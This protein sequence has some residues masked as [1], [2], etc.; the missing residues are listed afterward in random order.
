M[1]RQGASLEQILGHFYPG[2]ALS[3]SSGG[4]LRVVVHQVNAIPSEVFLAFPNGGEVRQSGGS[5]TEGFPVRVAPGEQVRIVWNGGRYRVDGGTPTRPASQAESAE[6]PVTG[7]QTQVTTPSSTTT[8]STTTPSSTTT[9]TAAIF[10]RPTTTTTTTPGDA[11][12]TT[13]TTAPAGT[14]GNSPES[15]VPLLASPAGGG[16][17]TI[18]VRGRTY[19]GVLE[20]S[21]SGGP[22]RVVNVVDVET[23]LKGMGEVR[24]PR[25]PAAALRAQ[26]VV[27]RTYALRAMSTSGELCDTQRC[28]VYL[29]AQAEYAAMNKAVEDTRGQVVLF[30]GR[31]ASTVYSANSGGHSATPEEGFGTANNDYPYLRAAPNPSA[32]PHAWTV[33]VALYDLARRF[34]YPGEVAEVRIGRTGPSGRALE[35]ILDGAAGPR[36]VPGIFFDAKLG[37]KST[38][39][40]LRTELSDDVPPPPDESEGAQALPDEV[41]AITSASQVLSAQLGVP[42]LPG[43]AVAPAG[44]APALLRPIEQGN[45]LP[46]V[47]AGLLGVTA[48]GAGAIFTRLRRRSRQAPPGPHDDWPSDF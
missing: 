27:A 34:G 14:T 10:P 26:A 39:F 6:V 33:K 16:A 24:D 9:T 2:T 17:V 8:T 38:L 21:G 32:D 31:L 45:P 13:T 19:R 42:E 20:V 44:D 11:T 36:S 40:S 46:A 48:V 37:L 3:R 29:G 30:R 25:W 43:A 1:G 35:V 28:Q 18:P 4:N 7:E 5:S 12:T 41:G 47:A 23:Y 15:A 22:L